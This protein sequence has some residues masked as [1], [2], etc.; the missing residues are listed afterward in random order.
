VFLQDPLVKFLML[1]LFLLSIHQFF[2]M[3][4]L[5]CLHTGVCDPGS[6]GPCGFC[7]ATVNS[8]MEQ[9]MGNEK[10]VGGGAMHFVEDLGEGGC[11]KYNHTI[12]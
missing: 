2:E 10:S 9:V 1:S 7:I 3:L 12:I 4:H 8:P 6:Q 5:L 11:R